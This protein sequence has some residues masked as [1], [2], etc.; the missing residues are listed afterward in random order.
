MDAPP[1]RAR[2]VRRGHDVG[3]TNNEETARQNTYF[4]LLRGSSHTS[5]QFSGL[6][7]RVQ[8]EQVL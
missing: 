6:C 1:A 4:N 5:P 2:L 3:A 8:E 7:S